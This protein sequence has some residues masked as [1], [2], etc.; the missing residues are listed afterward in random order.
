MWT[1]FIHRLPLLVYDLYSL[2][3]STDISGNS[4]VGLNRGLFEDE[5]RMVEPGEI[6]LH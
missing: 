6:S 5:S 4:K 3:V 1:I 2:L